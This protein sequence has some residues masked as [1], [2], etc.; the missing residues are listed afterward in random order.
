MR[1]DIK[2]FAIAKFFSLLVMLICVGLIFLLRGNLGQ[3]EMTS[4]KAGVISIQQVLEDFKT[5]TG[6]YPE[7]ITDIFSAFDADTIAKTEK[8][9]LSYSVNITFDKYTL[10]E[11]ESIH[12]ARKNVRK[13]RHQFWIHITFG[14]AF[15]NLFLV[16]IFQKV[17]NTQR[18]FT[19]K[20]FFDYFIL[21]ALFLLMLLLAIDLFNLI[22]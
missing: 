10:D 8:L 22:S 13:A 17:S 1:T 9:N 2:Y 7:K 5:K 6:K 19:R 4:I 20:L 16:R 12:V 11:E 21:S 15:I 14:I 18:S 3:A